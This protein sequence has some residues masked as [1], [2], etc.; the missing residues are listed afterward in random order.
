M[1][2]STKH[3]EYVLIEYLDW[4]LRELGLGQAKRHLLA[5][6]LKQFEAS[7]EPVVENTLGSEQTYESILLDAKSKFRWEPWEEP[8]KDV[9][10]QRT[11]FAGMVA[12]VL[13]TRRGV[14][15]LVSLLIT[16][17]LNRKLTV[18]YFLGNLT[19]G[20]LGTVYKAIPSKQ[21]VV[22][23]ASRMNEIEVHNLLPQLAEYFLPPKA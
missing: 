1:S 20:G 15:A 17:P 8:E 12:S 13:G 6:D 9:F 5:Q 18:S 3:Q 14:K 7:V 2:N 19:N 4:C 10:S 11:M 16:E 21:E 22:A 23:W